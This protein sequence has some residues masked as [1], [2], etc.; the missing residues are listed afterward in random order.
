[1]ACKVSKANVLTLGP[2]SVSSMS[3]G[4][5]CKVLLCTLSPSKESDDFFFFSE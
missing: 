2:K 1:M 4:L 5:Q 3:H